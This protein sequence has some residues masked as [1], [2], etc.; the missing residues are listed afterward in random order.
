MQVEESGF[1]VIPVDIFWAA[2]CLLHDDIEQHVYNQQNPCPFE[3]DAVIANCD[4]RIH[5]IYS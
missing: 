1:Q 2:S 3:S 5:Q 4:E